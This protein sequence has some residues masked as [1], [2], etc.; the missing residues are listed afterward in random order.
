MRV[1]ECNICG[2]CLS[3]ATDAELVG[4]LRGHMEERHSEASGDESETRRLV[5][6]QAYEAMDS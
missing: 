4:V 6:E 2:Q 1:I 5:A 3:A